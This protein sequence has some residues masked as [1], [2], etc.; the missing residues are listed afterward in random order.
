MCSRPT[1]P[2]GWQLSRWQLLAVVQVAVVW[3]PFAW[4]SKKF[5]GTICFDIGAIFDQKSNK[6]PCF[7]LGMM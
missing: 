4:L 2:L 3:I 6:I 5:I 7:V 1:T